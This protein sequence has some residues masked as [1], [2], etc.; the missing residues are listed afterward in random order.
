MPP[1]SSFAGRPLKELLTLYSNCLS[2]DYN[3]TFSN[4][5]VSQ[6]TDLTLQEYIFACRQFCLLNHDQQKCSECK[7]MCTAGSFLLE[8]GFCLLSSLFRSSFPNVTYKSENAKRKLIR[9]PIAFITVGQPSGGNSAVYVMEAIRGFNYANLASLLE[10]KFDKELKQQ[11]TKEQVMDLLSFAQS[12]RERECL[13]Y[14]VYQSPGLSA[15]GARRLY[16]WDEMSRRSELVETCIQECNEI[17]EAIADVSSVQEVCAERLLGVLES[18]S[19]SSTESELDSM[20]TCSD[21]SEQNVSAF[22]PHKTELDSFLISSGFNW[23]Q[24]VENVYEKCKCDEVNH[25]IEE[26]LEKYFSRLSCDQF[27]CEQFRLIQQSHDA[28]KACFQ[29]QTRDLAAVNGDIVSDSESE[30]DIECDTLSSYQPA[31]AQSNISPNHNASLSSPLQVSDQKGLMELVNKKKSSIRRKARYL[32]SKLIAKQRFLGRK[33][34]RKVSK[35]LQ[36]CPDIGKEIEKFVQERNI[37]ADAWRRTGILTFDGNTNLK[38]KVTFSRIKQHLEAVYKRHFSFG[39]VVQLCVARNKRRKSADR[40]KGVAQVTCRRARKGFKLRYNPDSHWSSAL[41]RSLNKLQYTDGRHI[42]NINR[43]DASG[44]RLNSMSTHRLHKTPVVQGHEALTTY[45]DY[46]NSYPST[47]QTT[48]YNFTGTETTSEVCVGVVKA[49]GVYTKNPA[50]HAADLSFLEKQDSLKCVFENKLIECARVDGAMDEGPS[51]EEVQFFWAARHLSSPTVFTLVTARSGGS[52]Y[53]NR[54]ELQNGC[55]TLA[56]ANLF[57]PSTLGGPCI[58]NETGKI[59]SDKYELNMQL[60]TQAYVS[61]VDGCP[62]GEGTIRLFQGARSPQNQELR[63]K[64]LRFLKGSKTAQAALKDEDPQAYS[65]ISKVWSIRT[66][67]LVKSPTQY[68]F[69]L[70]CCYKTGCQHPFCVSGSYKELQWFTDGPAVSY[71]PYP[72][73]DPTRPWG[74]KDC[75]ECDGQ[76]VC[77]GHFLKPDAALNSSLPIMEKPPSTIIRE[78]FQSHKTPTDSQIEQVAKSA[79]LSPNEVKMW[80]SHLQ[81]VKENRQRGARK[82]ALT[83]RQKKAESSTLA[84]LTIASEQN[85]ATVESASATEQNVATVESAS[86]T[87]QNVATEEVYYCGVCHHEFRE[88]TNTEENWIQCDVCC[89]WFHFACVGIKRDQVPDDF[90]CDNCC[91]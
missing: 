22:F 44:F 65:Y 74:S 91:D 71:L 63:S 68:V 37:G 42:V 1:C 88:F 64:L 36:D 78:F 57:I 19:G 17:R 90:I 61:R 25:E 10:S 27:T 34:T 87:E 75:T 49:T 83:R 16:G 2:S 13:R 86:A 39:S 46:L 33:Q 43:D 11:P 26:K 60:A 81:L 72:I 3:K 15:S 28:M 85:V 30:S 21:Q 77:F 35:I 80:L 40:Y 23:F 50:Q 32:K 53:L 84:R 56:H 51:H 58:N 73:K 52:S 4:I 18:D 55:L 9:M 76:N 20:S 7:C 54:V 24:L 82:A 6:N 89:A 67:H 38:Q 69:H 41:Y 59:D 29:K 62:C 66:N 70:K 5:C 8:Q 14:A 48:S 47:L 79:L 45:T 12:D 31:D